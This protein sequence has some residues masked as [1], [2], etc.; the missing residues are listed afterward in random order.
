MPTPFFADL[1]RE[2]AQE[3]GTGPLTPGGAV[4]GHRRF[5]D[6]VPAETD[7][8]YAV[9]GVARPEQWEVGTGHIDSAGRLVRASVAASSDGGAHVDFAAGLKTI[10]LTVGASWFA[11]NEGAIDAVGGAVE[12]L[13]AVVAAKQPL[14]TTHGAAATGMAGDTLTV[15]RGDGWVNIPLAT[16]P[17]RGSAGFHD[18]T[19]A[20]GAVDGSAVAAGIGFSG[21][22]DTG[23]FRADAD[24]LALTTGGA[25][26]VRVTASG[27]VGIGIAAPGEKLEIY[28]G[29]AG[30][31]CNLAV[32]NAATALQIGID[33]ANQVQFRTA[34]A[35]PM[36]FYAGG[37]E[38]LRI[39][40]GG[41]VRGGADNGQSIGSAAVR[42][43]T[44]YAGTGAINTSDTRDKVWRGGPG[45]AERRAARRISGELGFFQWADA[46]AEKGADKARHHFGVRAQA[47]WA[48][49]A[50]EGLID[51]I[52]ASGRPGATPY[53]FLCWD[54]WED[55]A[56]GAIRCRFGL[57]LD[58][59]ALFLIAAIDVRLAALEEAA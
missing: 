6:S 41:A 8:H 45:A 56:D 53:A 13:A 21:D 31:V 34:Q 11:A 9:V 25:E 14:S 3:G 10:A 7:F 5:A 58:Q 42:W 46:I 33:T 40:A 38:R 44:V 24:T 54:E 18:L 36:L 15:T 22:R 57:R 47:V 55:E 26:R 59:L 28:G 23:L 49:M 39:E 19:G 29:S 1:V 48:I 27:R 12:D 20:L 32:G 4:P 30:S 50:D 2:L 43:S 16:L 17:F 37:L 51:P 35:V 52:D